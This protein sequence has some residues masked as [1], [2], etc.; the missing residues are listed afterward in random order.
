MNNTNAGNP[1]PEDENNF[2][3]T[4]PF[5]EIDIAGIALDSANAGIWIM[6]AAS[7]KFLPSKRTK[8]LFGFLPD[9][10]M[11]FEAAM[12]KVVAKHRNT[13]AEAIENAFKERRTLN[14]E[15]PIVDL[16]DHNRRWLSVTGGYSSVPAGNSYFS[17]IVMD[18]TEQKQS[19]LRRSKFIGMVSHEL[20]TPLTTIKAYVQ[21]LNNWARKQKDNFTT[22][23]LSK[24][25]KQVT[26]MLNMINSLLNLSSVE[27]GKIH[28]KK[29]TF[30][31]NALI[32]EVVEETLFV[33][34]T[35][36]IEVTHCDHIEVEAD[37]DKIAGFGQFAQQ[38]S[39]I[40][41]Q[42]FCY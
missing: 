23:A 13:V 26:K 34:S 21:L 19:D 22:G 16:P 8:E 18:I 41:C 10:E 40:L 17:G 28:L 36:P 39:Q 2:S 4:E 25:E 11:S 38:R 37:R 24:V 30:P 9:E 3:L 14:I 27:A 32:T 5:Q 12:L 42:R 33:T 29:E 20:K 31:L 7:K 1:A 15:Y 35:H 6:D